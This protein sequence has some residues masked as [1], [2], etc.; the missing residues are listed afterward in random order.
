MAAPAWSASVLHKYA[1]AANILN[2][3]MLEMPRRLHFAH[4]ILYNESIFE[5]LF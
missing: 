2:C 4:V 3:A 5:L 1:G